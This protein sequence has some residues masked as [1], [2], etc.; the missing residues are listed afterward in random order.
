MNYVGVI[1]MGPPELVPVEAWQRIVD[2]NLF[3]VVRSNLVFLPLIIEQRRGH[4][5]TI[6]TGTPNPDPDP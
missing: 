2:V 4:V 5:V 6:R 3:S 1:A